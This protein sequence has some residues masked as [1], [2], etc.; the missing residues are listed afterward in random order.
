[1]DA[2]YKTSV[3]DFENLNGKLHSFV[4]VQSILLV[5]DSNSFYLSNYISKISNIIMQK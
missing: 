1:M 3:V 4:Y 2:K 5:L